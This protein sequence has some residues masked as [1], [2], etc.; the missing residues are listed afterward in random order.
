MDAAAPHISI[1]TLGV[2]DL[3]AARA[4]YGRWGLTESAAS[5]DTVV[6]FDMGGL[7][8]GLFGWDALAEDAGV[9]NQGDG[10]RG[11]ALAWNQPDAAAVDAVIARAQEAGAALVKPAQTV[12]W[13]GYSGYVRD[14]DGHLWEIAYNPHSPLRANGALDLPPPAAPGLGA[15]PS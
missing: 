1:L 13:G 8:L 4:F 7:A 6:F 5:T 2:A 10:F 11:V 3:T 14:P 12:F 15:S 9:S